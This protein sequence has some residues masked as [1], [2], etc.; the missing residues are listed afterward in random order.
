MS[1]AAPRNFAPATSPVPSRTRAPIHTSG[2]RPPTAEEFTTA[3][4]MVELSGV[5]EPLRAQLDHVDGRPRSL[6]VEGLLV[7]MQVNALRRHHRAQ[8]VEAARMLNAFSAR[9]LAA[10][11]VTNWNPVEAYDRTD[12][13]FNLLDK[14]LKKG[15][16]AMVDGEPVRIDA[17][18]FLER[19]LR[20]SIVG[21]PATSSAVAIDGTDVQGWGRLHGELTEDDVDQESNLDA[22]GGV[23]PARTRAA[24]R[25]RPLKVFGVGP[26]GRNI[27]TKDPD[28]RAGH[29]SA[30]NSRAGGEY[31][32]YELHLGVQIRDTGWTDG[33]EKLNLG[34]DVPSVIKMAS[35]V[36]AGSRR[37]DAVVSKLIDSKQRWLDVEEVV[38]DRG[39][40]Q[41]RPET[42]THPL[43]QAGIRQTFRTMDW[44]RK[45]KP[46]DEHT[47]LVEGL[48]VSTHVPAELQGL[49]PMPPYGSTDEQSEE[50]EEAFNRLARYALQRHAGPDA[51]GTTRWKCP[52][53]AGRL[54]SRSVP[55]SMRGSRTSPLV[56]LPEGSC[57]GGIVSVQAGELPHAQR[58]FPGTTA[59]RIA[60]RRRDAVEGVNGA[61][62]DT[63]VNVGQKFFKVFGLVKIKI[64]LA[65]TLAAYN[66]E[67]IRSFVARK[68]VVE[69][70][71]KKPR[72]RKKRR[73]QTWRDVVAVHPATG[74]DPPPG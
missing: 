16:D 25:K 4:R 68:T 1:D 17:D 6:S 45:A 33:I 37:D 57:C 65:F 54:R 20:A 53:D 74:P 19:W 35:L 50:F 23:L 64:L 26:D 15:W 52:F 10:L 18:W 42:T 21:L 29:R 38:W 32:G 12:R 71:A 41:L 73:K 44:Q 34:P 27:Y 72:R 13:L 9:Q 55:K 46:F 66:L 11:G 7:A 51:D 39:Y 2:G 59:W 47:M 14:A 69:E 60:Y 28:A 43:N 70:E 49:L 30:V 22:E 48:L 24:R 62:K 8:V 3:C 5:L 61:L 67:I 63:F 58:F 40:S 36:P 56:D 31:V